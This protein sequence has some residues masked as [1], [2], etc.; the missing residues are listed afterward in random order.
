MFIV[1]TRGSRRMVR[2]LRTGGNGMKD[3][4]VSDEGTY[5]SNQI[6]LVDTTGWTDADWEKLE[7]AG[8]SE[9][10]EVAVSIAEKHGGEY[11]YA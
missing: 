11:E 2:E 8:D 4:W 6:V 3:L 7:D 1:S 10:M 5:G 9:R